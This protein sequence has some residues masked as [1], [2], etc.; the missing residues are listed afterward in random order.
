MCRPHSGRPEVRPDIG[1]ALA[2]GLAY[3]TALDI[4]KPDLIGPLGA[5][6]AHQVAAGVIGAV[7][8]YPVDALGAH[9]AEGDFLRS[10]HVGSL[11]GKPSVEISGWPST[12][13]RKSCRKSIVLSVL[14]LPTPQLM[15]AFCV[16]PRELFP[17][18]SARGSVA[19]HVLP[20][21]AVS[22]NEIGR[23]LRRH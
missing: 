1:A 16:L 12:R 8:Q 19:Q 14:R 13:P 23:Q 20:L 2:A 10:F 3:K 15:M 9:L 7:D 11:P 17:C 21:T 6:H 18:L 4:G 22:P 5:V